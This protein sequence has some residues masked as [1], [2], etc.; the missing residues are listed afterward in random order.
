MEFATLYFRGRAQKEA[1][2]TRLADLQH[3]HAGC[4][5]QD[6]SGRQ[7]T[8]PEYRLQPG[9]QYELRIP[10]VEQL[11]AEAHRI[12]AVAFRQG[13]LQIKLPPNHLARFEQLNQEILS[14]SYFYKIYCC[15]CFDRD[16]YDSL[17]PPPPSK[18]GFCAFAN[19]SLMD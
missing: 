11:A 16:P 2:G 13:T 12:A 8:D 7:I 19:D 6:L 5:I 4:W 9:G 18:V 15:M 14:S 1:V 10:E 17:L 3:S